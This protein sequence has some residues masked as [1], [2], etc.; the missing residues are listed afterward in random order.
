MYGTGACSRQPLLENATLRLARGC[1]SIAVPRVRGLHCSAFTLKTPRATAALGLRV[2]V[3]LAFSRQI[4]LSLQPATSDA[5]FR[6][7]IL[8]WLIAG[9]RCTPQ[10]CLVSG[11]S[12]AHRPSTLTLLL[13]CGLHIA[14]QLVSLGWSHM[15]AANSD[16]VIGLYL[17]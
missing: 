9:F 4:W 16:C 5:L 3:F 8:P 7:A 12:F 13:A 6:Q 14:F 2:E 15:T 10:R 17:P 1:R 11:F